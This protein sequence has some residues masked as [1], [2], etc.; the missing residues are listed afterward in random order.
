MAEK[1]DV[2]I[3]GSL[4]GFDL[5]LAEALSGRG[6]KC[7]VLRSREEE[8]T[9]RNVSGEITPLATFFKHFDVA[10]VDYFDSSVA[11]VRKA[12]NCKLILS[13]TLG[14][15]QGLKYL[16]PCKYLR[17]FPPIINITTGADITELIELKSLKGLLYRHH[18][19]S[20]ALNW[21]AVYPH[22]IKNTIRFKLPN[23]AF[24]RLPYN[25]PDLGATNSDT[26]DE[27]L[28]FHPT[29]LD[30]KVRNPGTRRNSSNGNDRFIKALARA[31]QSGLKARCIILFRGHDR[32]EARML[33]RDLGMADH[34]TFL[35]HL[36]RDALFEYF[37]AADVVVDQFDIGGM[38]GIAM[39]A[40]SAHRTVITYINENCHR[41]LYGDDIPPVL[42]CWSEDEILARILECRDREL[43]HRKGAQGHD[44]VRR[45]HHWSN[46]LDE[47]LFYCSLLS[48][49][50]TEDYGWN[51]SAYANNPDS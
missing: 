51:E 27:L 36:D 13:V 28:F 49:S 22:A 43:L 8:H 31:I 38:G 40:M 44:W 17:S 7:T 5:T 26:G 34:F 9:N 3:V 39:E 41:L 35:P 50:V 25:V 14:V 23:I 46:C 33:I 47:L 37:A 29:N 4:C 20:S 16:Y 11:F 48:G 10:S 1:Y 2:G 6:L 30:W 15:L 42:N 18:L 12:T 24:M 19:R 45:N 21:I 32:E